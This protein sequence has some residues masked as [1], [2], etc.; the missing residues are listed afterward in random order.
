MKNKIISF[1]FGVIG[2]CFA[3]FVNKYTDAKYLSIVM[4]YFVGF[5]DYM[6]LEE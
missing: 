5:C 3:Y 6:I 1:L 2:L 4:A